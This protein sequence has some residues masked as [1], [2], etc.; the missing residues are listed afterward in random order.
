MK[1]LKYIIVAVVIAC[2]MTWLQYHPILEWVGHILIGGYLVALVL[3]A[4]G[5]GMSRKNLIPRI[6]IAIFMVLWGFLL[7]FDEEYR[8]SEITAI[9]IET[10]KYDACKKSGIDFEEGHLSVCNENGNWWRYG[11]TEAI[12][13]DSSGQIMRQHRPHSAGWVNAALTLG[14]QAPFGSVGFD[15]R[16]LVGDFYL[17]TFYDDLD[18][19]LISEC[20]NIHDQ[21]VLRQR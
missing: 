19:E 11:F 20:R 1:V 8:W 12:I 13:Y 17:V 4:L 16:H 5:I 3:S 6:A 18:D 10:K 2:A 21:C 15:A 14:K 9:K 7:H